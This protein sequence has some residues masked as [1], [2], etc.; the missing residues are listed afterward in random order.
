MPSSIDAINK[1]MAIEG[2]FVNNPLDRGGATNYGITQKVYENFVGRSVSVDEIK[3]MP[4]GNAVAIYQKNYWNKIRGDD[5]KDF[6]VAYAIF[7]QAVNRGVVASVKQAQKVVG[8]VSD[9]IMGTQSINAI[10]AMN[11]GLFL[12]RYLAESENAYKQIVANNPSQSVFIKGWLNRVDEIKNYARQV[13]GLPVVKA[14]IG[15]GAIALLS[16]GIFLFLRS[17][18]K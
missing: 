10:N 12:Q 17:R 16:L 5:I 6:A 14:G 2:G 4:R 11:P 18:K 8:A 13:L 1:V 15:L 7:D 9:G 3:N